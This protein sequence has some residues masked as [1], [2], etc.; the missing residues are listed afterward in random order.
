MTL[1]VLFNHFYPLFTI[2]CQ[3]RSLKGACQEKTDFFDIFFRGLPMEIGGGKY[4][5]RK[6]REK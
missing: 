5:P 6:G 3:Y 4:L 1:L 2:V